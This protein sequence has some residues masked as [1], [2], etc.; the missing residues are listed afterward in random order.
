MPTVT[1]VTTRIME[2]GSS[3]REG[4][5]GGARRISTVIPL[6]N[7][8]HFIDAALASVAAQSCP[9][10][11]VIVVDDASED[12][13]AKQ[14]ARWSALLPLRVIRHERNQGLGATRR[15]GIEASSGELVALLDADDVWLPDHLETMLATWCRHGGL[16]TAD[17]LWWSPARNISRITGRDRKRIPPP[18]RQ[19][20]GILDH[21]FVHPLTLFSRTDYERAGGFSELRKMEDWDLWIRMVRLGITVTMA[22]TPT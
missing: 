15:T 8:A 17:S 19:R 20:L 6:Y 18:D 2:E 4:R 1:K 13:G 9:S 22:P 3:A 14:A 5:Q 16:V 21:N 10:D 11:E 12:D 7:S